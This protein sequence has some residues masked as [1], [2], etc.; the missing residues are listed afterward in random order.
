MTEPAFNWHR[1]ILEWKRCACIF[2]ICSPCAWMV[3]WFKTEG[4]GYNSWLWR[5]LLIKQKSTIEKWPISLP[6]SCPGH[7]SRTLGVPMFQSFSKRGIGPST[8]A[9][10]GKREKDSIEIGS[11][12]NRGPWVRTTIRIVLRAPV[13]RSIM[14]P[15][16]PSTLYRRETKTS[17]YMQQEYEEFLRPLHW[18][19]STCAFFFF[20]V[21]GIFVFCDVAVCIVND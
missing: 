17:N 6:G 12:I 4:V 21:R 5:L 2:Y 20:F 8:R 1:N 16:K 7:A 19:Q 9:T 11:I 15:K 3:S 14:R 13:L 18:M 10:Q